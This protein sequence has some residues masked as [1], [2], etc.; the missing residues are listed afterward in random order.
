V[1]TADSERGVKGAIQIN[2]PEQ[3]DVN[4]D[5]LVIPTDFIN[6]VALQTT[7]CYQRSG[8]DVSHFV[9]ASYSGT[10]PLP[11]DIQQIPVML[12]MQADKKTQHIQNVKRTCRHE[13]D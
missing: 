1:I 8:N 5:L 2:N 10:P 9:D 11:E 4:K 6:A 13:D 3:A 12:V 7:P